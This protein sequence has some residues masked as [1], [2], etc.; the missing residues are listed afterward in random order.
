MPLKSPRFAGNVRLEKAAQN[1]PAMRWRE[2]GEPV[3]LIQQAFIDL[4]FPMPISIKK[5]G[6]PDGIFGAE[7]YNT[8]KKFQAKFGLSIDGIVGHLTM[9][10]LD[11]LLPTP[12]PLPPAPPLIPYRVPGVMSL[13]KQPSGMACWATAYTMMENWKFAHSTSIHD[14]LVPLGH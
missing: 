11:A 5:L 3:R 10:K 12:H 6:S 1:S 4:G 14:A 9:A 13:L 7:T 2:S 8:T